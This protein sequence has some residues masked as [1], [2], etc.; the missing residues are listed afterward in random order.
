M[1]SRAWYLEQRM[2]EARRELKANLPGFENL[3]G[4]GRDQHDPL[5]P[6]LI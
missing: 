3:A 1:S 4:F 6:Y 2:V 5:G